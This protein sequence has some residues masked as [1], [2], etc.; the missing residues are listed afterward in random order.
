MAD[1]KKTIEII[2][3]GTDEATGPLERIGRGFERVNDAA[4]PFADITKKV[5]ALEAALAGM[6][7]AGLAYAYQKAV[8]FDSALVGLKKVLGDEAIP[9]NLDKINTEVTRLSERYGI[10]TKEIIASVAGWKQAGFDTKEALQ[11]AGNALD[12]VIAGDVSASQSTE[13]LV[14]A[15]KGFNLEAKEAPR[16]LDVINEISNRYA[17][18]AKQ[19][20][21]ALSELS[22]IAGKM[23]L[24]LEQ[25]A[26]LVTPIIEVFR[27]GSESTNALKIGLQRLTSDTIPVVKALT[28]L[29]V[30][31]KDANGN[32]R[33]AYEIF[34]DVAKAFKG[35][36]KSQQAFY[37]QELVGLEQS[38]RF[39]VALDN[40]SKSANITAVAL[41]SSG[42]AV[43]EVEARLQ[44]SETA[45]KRFGVSFENLSVAIG[46]KYRGAVDD[47]IRS[48]TDVNK[49]LKGLVEAGDFDPLFKIITDVADDITA[50]LKQFAK[51]LPKALEGVDFGEFGKSIDDL[52]GGFFDADFNAEDLK[53]SIQFVV[54]SL[55][56]LNNTV[57]GVL[58]GITP[59][60]ELVGWGVS[61]FNSLGKET[62]NVVGA[63]GGLSIAITATYS[64]LAPFVTTV[65]GGVAAATAFG[66]A[67]G[68]LINKLEIV[69]EIAQGLIKDLDEIFKFTDSK[70]AEE[71]AVI[72]SN[73]QKAKVQA[74]ETRQKLIE[75]KNAGGDIKTNISIEGTEQVEQKIESVEEKAKKIDGKQL[76][77]DAKANVEVKANTEPAKKE[78]KEKIIDPTKELEITAKLETDR[79]KNDTERLKINAQNLQQYFEYKAK[80]DVAQI[81]AES[82][83][84]ENSFNSINETISSAGGLIADLYAAMGDA[85]IGR[86][87]DIE[88]QID[89]EFEMRKESFELQKKLTEEQIKAIEA[90][91]KLYESGDA[92]V[93]VQADGLK[94]ALDMIFHEVLEMTQTRA[95]ADGIDLL[96][97]I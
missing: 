5:L 33:T 50:F 18:D 60:F 46:N 10:S 40:V 91:R 78:I 88:N 64:I 95:T 92:L 59:F 97:G 85:D 75:I 20:G 36:D 87:I 62:Q 72:D 90:R 58:T 4:Q 73:F 41:N 57:D 37:T 52:V 51:E 48:A 23:G 14:A 53:N 1:I 28:K 9:E 32:F 2:F 83:N 86:Q 65:S 94:P 54:D 93:T 6:A 29:G 89:D 82:K 44:S 77:I 3:F 45:V 17:T 15:L 19:L 39:S 61:Y 43:A 49:A 67:I 26:G 13:L 38:A 71:I 56:S 24:S 27:S 16:Y 21:I 8:E 84:I 66:Y 80:V 35:M 63:F 30:S 81:E 42:S 47:I 7:A 68:T 70:T 79:F 11:L 31:Q 76:K 69:Q 22:P 55:T 96:L 34:L 74:E 12:F 25:A